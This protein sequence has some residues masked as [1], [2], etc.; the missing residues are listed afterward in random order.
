MGAVLCGLLAFAQVLAFSH[1]AFVAHRTCALHGESVHAGAVTSPPRLTS[2]HP[3]TSPLAGDSAG[4]VHEHCLC[5]AQARARFLLSPQAHQ[6]SRCPAV[7]ADHA[8]PFIA[9]PASPIALLLL[10]PKSSP[11]A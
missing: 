10:A 7:A 3:S 6:A 8:I 11:P 4:H 1:A 9:R 5:M 2:S